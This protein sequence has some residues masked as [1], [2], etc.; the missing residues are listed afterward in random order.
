MFLVLGIVFL[1]TIG[2]AQE[3]IPLDGEWQFALGPQT[4]DETF[5]NYPFSSSI[6]KNFSNVTIP[7]TWNDHPVERV[8][9][10]EGFYLSKGWYKKNF[11][12]FKKM[13]R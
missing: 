4:K 2:F 5:I 1:S 6:S 9:K 13:E 3:T 10:G 11:C 8:N 12:R 7:H